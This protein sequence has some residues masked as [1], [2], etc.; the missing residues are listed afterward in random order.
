MRHS[1]AKEKLTIST[2]GFLNVH[3]LLTH[4]QLKNVT[5][6]DIK[7]VVENNNKQRF[8]LRVNEGVLQI[9]ANQGHSFAVK[10]LDLT[11]INAA[12]VPIVIHGTYM[13]FWPQILE[14]GLSRMNRNHIHFTD[15]LDY[16]IRKDANLYI[17]VNVPKA[18]DSG[19]KFFRSSNAVILCSGDEN[20]IIKT[21]FFEKV[22]SR[23]G[24]EL[25][26]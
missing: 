20:G 9:R 7:R 12:E 24:L 2:D 3:E 5:V 22:C 6:N 17:Y 16:K 10:D 19:L 8:T 1:A 14:K 4:P 18:V 13:K 23:D 25:K 15:K 11:P 26:F 21:S